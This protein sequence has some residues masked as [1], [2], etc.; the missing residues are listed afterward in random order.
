MTQEDI[1][2]NFS[3]NLI[4]LRHSQNLTQLQLA[5]KLNYSD[6]SISKWEVGS[7][8]PDIETLTNIAEFFGVTVNALIYPQKKKISIVFLQNHLFTTLIAFFAVW[9]VATIVYYVMDSVLDLNRLWLVF[10]ITIPVSFVVLIVFSSMWFKKIWLILSISG[11]LWGVLL[12]VYLLVNNYSLWFIFIVGVV[13]QIV[14]LLSSQLK[15][16]KKSGIYKNIKNDK[17]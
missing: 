8:L 3:Q 17:S 14:T 15:K 11:L 4:K 1:K 16:L 5:E 13:G 2:K 9:L 12:S 10:I 6:K 7:V